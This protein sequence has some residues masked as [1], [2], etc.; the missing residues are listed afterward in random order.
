MS[1]PVSVVKIEM[2][3]ADW[4]PTGGA[5]GDLQVFDGQD[6]IRELTVGP[7]KLVHEWDDRTSVG[8]N[9]A[10]MRPNSFAHYE[11]VAVRFVTERGA[12]GLQKF[13][14]NAEANIERPVTLKWTYSTGNSDEATF[15]VGEIGNPFD[16]KKVVI[17]ECMFIAYG[18]YSKTRA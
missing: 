17:T 1:E 5:A 10:Q 7:F 18:S 6:T 13:L 8:D 9:V 4:T 2:S 16:N 11:N 12:T 15:G 3:Q 14:E